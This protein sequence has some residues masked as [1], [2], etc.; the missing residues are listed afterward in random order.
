MTKSYEVL[1]IQNT[2]DITLM[3]AQILGSQKME[4]GKKNGR[5]GGLTDRKTDRLF[6]E[7]TDRLI[8]RHRRKDCLIEMTLQIEEVEKQMTERQI[9]GQTER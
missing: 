7:W 6:D 8:G 3:W 4:G 5:T 1:D 2:L 9:I